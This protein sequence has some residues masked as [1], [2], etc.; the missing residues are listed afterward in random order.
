MQNISNTAS[1]TLYLAA[2]TAA[3][4]LD[5]ITVSRILYIY[6]RKDTISSFTERFSNEPCIFSRDHHNKTE[7]YTSYTTSSKNRNSSSNHQKARII[8]DISPNVLL[9]ILLYWTL[10]KWNEN[11]HLWE[12]SYKLFTHIYNYTS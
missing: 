1:T 7:L 10:H 4:P 11:F 9:K 12:H 5:F 8:L 3:I 6:P 2:T